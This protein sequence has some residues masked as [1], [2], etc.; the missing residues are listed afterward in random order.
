MK[1][2]LFYSG[3]LRNLAETIENNI[4][5]FP[6]CEID[7]YIST[8]T[9]MGYSERINSPDYIRGERLIPNGTFVSDGLIRS[10][11]PEEVNIKAV[12][13]EKYV[14]GDYTFDLIGGLDNDGLPAQYYKIK[15]CYD[16]MDKEEDYDLEVRMRCDVL[17]GKSP[18]PLEMQET[19]ES[20]R[21]IFTEK[22]WYD[23]PHDPGNGC[24]NE[25][26]WIGR[27]RRVEKA[28]GIY[29][30]AEGINEEIRNQNIEAMK[31]NYGESICWMNLVSKGI[32]AD[33][34]TFDFDY[35]VV[36]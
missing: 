12:K 30:N 9:H 20:G 26:L 1:V 10:L 2:A 18:T 17:F 28:C 25:M 21:I 4:A 35:R 36:R 15:D 22:T 6:G 27:G 8:W 19:V 29:N 3:A 34:E 24:I 31:P 11:I 7:F 33:V 23:Y 13:I 32:G 16:L 14:P 5:I